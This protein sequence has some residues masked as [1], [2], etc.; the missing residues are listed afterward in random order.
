M[1]DGTYFETTIGWIGL[2]ASEKG[3]VQVLLGGRIETR[4]RRP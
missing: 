2:V 3:V 4:L 1:T